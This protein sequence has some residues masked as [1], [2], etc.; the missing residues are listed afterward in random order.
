MVITALV[1]I[2]TTLGSLLL[3][4]LYRKAAKSE[5]AMGKIEEANVELRRTQEAM[6]VILCLTFPQFGETWNRHRPHNPWP[7]WEE[8][9][10]RNGFNLPPPPPPPT[11]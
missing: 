11:A 6:I 3:G 4:G 10:A 8:L 9:A 2:A 7:T 5:K 1:G